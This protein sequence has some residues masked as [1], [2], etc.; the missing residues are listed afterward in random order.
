[1]APDPYLPDQDGRPGPLA[2]TTTPLTGITLWVTSFWMYPSGVPAMSIATNQPTGWALPLLECLVP[3]K[4]DGSWIK[5]KSK[6]FKDQYDYMCRQNSE[7]IA[8]FF[9]SITDDLA[10]VCWCKEQ[11]YKRTRCARVLVAKLSILLR[12]DINVKLDISNPA[13]PWRPRG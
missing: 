7:E 4:S 13:W 10:I 3:I 8:S 5:E 1:L 9:E 11:P 12:P 2:V 6:V